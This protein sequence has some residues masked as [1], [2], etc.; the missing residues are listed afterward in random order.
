MSFKLEEI[1]E[2][3]SQIQIPM[4]PEELEAIGVHIEEDLSA[5]EA[6]SFRDGYLRDVRS[7]MARRRRNDCR[8]ALVRSAATDVI[9]S[10]DPAEAYLAWKLTDSWSYDEGDY[11]DR[12]EEFPQSPL[13]PGD[14]LPE[15]FVGPGDALEC[16][17]PDWE[18]IN[19]VKESLAEKR[20][21]EREGYHAH[22]EELALYFRRYFAPEMLGFIK[23]KREALL[24]LLWETDDRRTKP[25]KRPDLPAV[26][27]EEARE[28]I[29]RYLDTLVVLPAVRAAHGDPSAARQ[30]VREALRLFCNGGEAPEG[31]SKLKKRVKG[32]ALD[33]KVLIKAS[34]LEAR[35][36]K[37]LEEYELRQEIWKTALRVLDPRAA[38]LLRPDPSATFAQKV[39]AAVVHS[40]PKKP[41]TE[42]TNGD[43]EKMAVGSVTLRAR[44]LIP[45]AYLT[46]GFSTTADAVRFLSD[47]ETQGRLSL[48]GPNWIEE[49]KR[50]VFGAYKR[51]R[52]G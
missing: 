52:Q 35:F 40:F 34:Q 3:L 6:E 4:K 21:E 30:R 17:F 15:G 44:P 14:G 47:P 1:C 2:E 38:Q 8:G 46:G 26:R 45:W 31:K 7:C 48:L 16:D 20:R 24:D 32:F 27:I 41:R 33:P 10:G 23:D 51:A 50:I 11:P 29:E 37:A 18:S 42:G 12:Y 28:R 39:I 19:R 13:V 22:L 9:F 49:I 36:Q 5:D 43:D 25:S